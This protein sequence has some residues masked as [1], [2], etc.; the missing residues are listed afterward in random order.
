MNY[1]I[2]KREHILSIEDKKRKKKF[3]HILYVLVCNSSHASYE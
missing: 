1:V 3:L 2:H